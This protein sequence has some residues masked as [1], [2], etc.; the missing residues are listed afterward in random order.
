MFFRSILL[1]LN[2]ESLL[3][4]SLEPDKRYLKLSESHLKFEVNLP[5]EFIPDN[6]FVAKLFENVD[7]VVNYETITQ[8]ASNSDY[9][10]S[11]FLLTKATFGR[12]IKIT[13]K[14]TSRILMLC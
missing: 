10:Y 3:E 2:L 13:K 12:G 4:F 1:I 5:E 8:K 14:M 7:I 9:Y 6:A 11:E